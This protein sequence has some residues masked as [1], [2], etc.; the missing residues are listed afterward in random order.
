[1]IREWGVRPEQNREGI[2]GN[3]RSILLSNGVAFK[4]YGLQNAFQHLPPGISIFALFL[5]R[6]ARRLF[7]ALSTKLASGTT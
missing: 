5:F 6:K 2:L 4:I 3:R 1:L 7:C